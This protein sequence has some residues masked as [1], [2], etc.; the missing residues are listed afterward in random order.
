M[1]K[2]DS[3]STAS[4]SKGRHTFVIS[5]CALL[6]IIPTVIAIFYVYFKEDDSKLRQNMFEILLFN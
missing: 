4:K 5:V 6:V 1:S 3:K 2:Q